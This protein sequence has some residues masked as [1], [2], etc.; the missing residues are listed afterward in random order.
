MLIKNKLSQVYHSL[1]SPDIL[2]IGI[3]EERYADCSKCHHC[4][5]KNNP[6]HHTKCCVYYP[7]IPNYMIGAILNAPELQEGQKR[8]K[9]IIK[10]KLGVTPYGIIPPVKHNKVYKAE[11]EYKQLGVIKQEVA[12]SLLCPFYDNGGC[13]IWSHRTELCSTFFCISSGGQKGKEFWGTFHR[14]FTAIEYKLSLY[15]LQK[16][17]Y[18]TEDLKVKA[19]QSLELQLDDDEG[20]LNQS[21]YDELWKD[22]KGQELEYYLKSYEEVQKLQPKDVENM[23]GI[24]EQILALNVS[25]KAQGF[26]EHRIP[27]KL[28]FTPNDTLLQKNENGEYE[29]GYQGK[30][31]EFNQI[32]FKF[33]ELFDG[34]TSTYEVLRKAHGVR[35]PINQLILPLMDLACLKTIK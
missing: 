30:K 16:M 10:E 4:L 17:G 27:E 20:K 28:L 25:K 12:N 19:I 1:L 13:S 24:E 7:V 26:N 33:L 29:V 35:L 18:P 11:V 34:E 9:K 3:P 32:Q 21:V 15:A 22:W 31:L 2:E 8:I 23:L 5:S 14:Y 6:L